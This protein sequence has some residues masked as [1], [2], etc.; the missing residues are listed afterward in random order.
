MPPSKLSEPTRLLQSVGEGDASAAQKLLPLVY[1]ELHRRARQMMQN[2]RAGHTLQPTALIHEAF[3]RPVDQDNL[4]LE[5]RLH[6]VRIAA[7]AMRHVLADHAR[8]RGR[9]KRGGGQ[10]PVT[11]D[12]GAVGIVERSADVLAVEDALTRLAKV[13][14]Q[15]ARIVELRFYG[16][17]EYKEVATALGMS[18]RSVERG[19]QVAR[20]WLASAMEENAMEEND[21]EKSAP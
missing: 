10:R 6:F 9:Q 18:L 11:L 1:D 12:E 13:D 8:A 15:L 7:S 16:G 14:E 17:L 21:T 4:E 5:S 3:L 20:A 19:W 2:R